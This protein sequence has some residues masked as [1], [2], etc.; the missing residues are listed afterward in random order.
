MQSLLLYFGV[1]ACA[2]CC[3]GLSNRQG[4]NDKLRIVLLGFGI[5]LPAVLAGLRSSSVGTDTENYLFEINRIGQQPFEEVL[6]AA[7]SNYEIGFRLLVK[8][9]MIVLGDANAVLGAL[10]ALT[11]LFSYA[12]IRLFCRGSLPIGLAFF[13]VLCLYWG[14]SLNITRQMLAASICFF[15]LRFVFDKQPLLFALFV[16]IAVTIHASSA[17]FLIA[18]LFWNPEKPGVL[19]GRIALINVTLAICGLL[20]IDAFVSGFPGFDGFFSKYDYLFLNTPGGN[21]GVILTFAIAIIMAMTWREF[22]SKSN[23]RT[24]FAIALFCTSAVFQLLGLNNK[25]FKRIALCFSLP[26]VTWFANLP[27]IAQPEESSL[28][29]LIIVFYDIA[30]FISTKAIAGSGQIIPYISI[31]G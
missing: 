28:V 1:F 6:G 31:W 5:L 27:S 23:D 8:L 3:I 25:F 12:G 10:N 14:D 29:A 9:L 4:V 20:I 30:Y 11:L 18:G 22:S 2:S 13:T 19:L 17:V 21:R 16:V 7:Y 24:R 26:S 15:S